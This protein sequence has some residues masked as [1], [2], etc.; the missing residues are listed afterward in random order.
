MND[1][2]PFHPHGTSVA[3]LIAGQDERV[4][5][6]S[7]DANILDIRV[8][9]DKGYSVTSVLSQGIVQATDLGAQVINIS[10][11]GYDDS[12]VLRDAVAYALQRNVI[13]LAAAGNDGLDVLAYPA[14]I[15]GVL[16][17][18]AVD[19]KDIQAYFS[20]SGQGLTL[21]APGVGLPVAW[22]ADKMAIASG[23]SQAVAVASGG[24]AYELGLGLSPQNAVLVL[25]Q[26]A[27]VTGAPK[28][29]VGNGVLRLKR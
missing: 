9:N 13:V 6:V 4:P 24:V 28:T 29:Q 12:Q 1:A 8:A 23:T 17:V 2:T 25:Q 20:N 7:P 19:A 18:G 21:V 15:T 5:G 26:N 27:L 14:A 11:G 22:A 3:S 10:M 16:S